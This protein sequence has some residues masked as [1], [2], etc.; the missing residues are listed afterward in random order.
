M[1]SLGGQPDMMF[2]ITVSANSNDPKNKQVWI[3][4]FISCKLGK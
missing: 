4:I 2:T 1:T 3:I